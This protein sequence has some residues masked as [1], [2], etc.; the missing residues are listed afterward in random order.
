MGFWYLV[1]N[2]TVVWCRPVLSNTI[3]NGGGGSFLWCHASSCDTNTHTHTHKHTHTNDYQAKPD[4]WGAYRTAGKAWHSSTHGPLY[5]HPHPLCLAH[6]GGSAHTHTDTHTH[7]HTHTQTCMYSIRPLQK[8][9]ASSIVVFFFFSSEDSSD[10]VLLSFL[11]NKDISNRIKES[12]DTHTHTQ[13]ATCSG[14]VESHTC[15]LCLIS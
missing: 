13:H 4:K 6:S 11:S 5:L 7:T 10:A 9:T 12:D 3:V 2:M 8:K 1:R 14:H 15:L